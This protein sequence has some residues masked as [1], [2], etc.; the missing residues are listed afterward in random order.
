MGPELE[1]PAEREK[2]PRQQQQNPHHREC[3]AVHIA[4]RLLLVTTAR[5]RVDLL[6]QILRIIQKRAKTADK[7]LAA[8]CL[9]L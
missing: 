1:E 6:S 4:G 5:G 3:S 9:S 2:G 7:L 8:A